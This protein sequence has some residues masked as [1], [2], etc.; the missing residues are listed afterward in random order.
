MARSRKTPPG[1]ASTPVARADEPPAPGDLAR[2]RWARVHRI[3]L[4][5]REIRESL[6][7]GALD[8]LLSHAELVVEGSGEIGTAPGH[9]GERVYVT[10]MLTIDL[11]R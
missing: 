2:P 11:S 8:L 5:R 6:S 3:R 9:I 10:L 4:I 7:A 1:P